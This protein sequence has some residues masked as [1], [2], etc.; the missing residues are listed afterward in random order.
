[1]PGVGEGSPGPAAAALANAIAHATQKRV[2]GLPFTPARV[3][4]ALG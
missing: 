1:M 4:Q 2:R 3:K